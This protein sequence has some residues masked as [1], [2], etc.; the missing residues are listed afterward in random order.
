M[1]T[2][3]PYDWIAAVSVAPFV[4]SFLSVLITRLPR[5]QDV[6][7]QPSHC[8]CCNQALAVRDLVP[9]VSFVVSNGACRFCNAQIPYLY[10]AIEV[11]A[12]MVAAC[13]ALLT[14]GWL[15]W[16]TCAL[17]WTLLALAVMDAREMVLS[18]YLTM[19]LIA[20]GLVLGVAINPSMVWHHVVGAAAGFAVIAGVAFLYLRLRDREG[21]G[22]GDAKLMAAAGAWLSWEALGGVLLIGAIATLAFAQIEKRFG[23]AM[24]TTTPLP[25]G[26]GLAL[27]FWVSWLCGPLVFA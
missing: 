1:I 7:L 21:V 8:P 22:L 3:S 13:A 5:R 18:D 27:G 17:G 6:V 4:G 25:L 23:R 2:S 26:S 14:A 19:P 15:L 11:A 20:F 10:P 24:S 12:V 16:V 9:V